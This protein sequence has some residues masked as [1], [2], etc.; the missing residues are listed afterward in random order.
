MI[1]VVLAGGG[2]VVGSQDGD[3]DIFV[4]VV[5]DEVVVGSSDLP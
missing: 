1:V 3:V 4:M 5:A 2:V